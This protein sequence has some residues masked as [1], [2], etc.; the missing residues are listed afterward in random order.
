MV[1]HRIF[2]SFSHFEVLCYVHGVRACSNCGDLHATVQLSLYHLLKRLSFFHGI[3]LLSSSQNNCP[4]F[5][6]LFLGSLFCSTYLC[7]SFCASTML[8]NY[9]NFVVQFKIRKFENSSFALPQNYFDYIGPFVIPYKFQDYLF[10]FHKKCHWYFDRDCT[11]SIF[12]FG[13]HE[14]FNNLNSSSPWVQFIIPF[15][16]IFFN[17]FFFFIF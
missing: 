7:V 6:G 8:S 1:S 12:C 13:Q 9:H 17:F 5:V 10:W 2:K 16:C 11:D 14:L 4:I 3:F 15:I